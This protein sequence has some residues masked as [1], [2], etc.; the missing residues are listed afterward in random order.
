MGAVP[1]WT[2]VAL[3]PLLDIFIGKLLWKIFLVVEIWQVYLVVIGRKMTRYSITYWLMDCS[4]SLMMVRDLE[5]MWLENQWH[6]FST[7]MWID[8]YKWTKDWRYLCLVNILKVT[9]VER[10]LN[11]QVDTMTCSVD[12]QK[13]VLRYHCHSK[14]GL[15]NKWQLEGI[16]WFGYVKYW[17]APLTWL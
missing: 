3:N 6:I 14:L 16:Y 2:T 10:D 15:W 12:R 5:A 13:P 17:T 9:V 1:N 11:N 8:F 7:C 4:Q